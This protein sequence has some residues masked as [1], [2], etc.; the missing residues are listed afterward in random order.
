[1]AA[2]IKTKSTKNAEAK[3]AAETNGGKIRKVYT[4]KDADAIA[5]MRRD[6]KSWDAISAEHGSNGIV[7]RKQLAKFGYDAKGESNEIE[8]ITLKGSAL[9][10]RLLAERAEGVAWYTLAIA[11]GET[12]GNLKAL[13][14][15]AGGDTGRVHAKA[16]KP[17]KAAKATKAKSASKGARRKTNKA[18]AGSAA[19]PS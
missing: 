10:K 12:E 8:P 18:A 2:K 11:T 15:E 6:K 9:V 16:E 19:D 7:L 4:E 14:E 17:A 5:K 3:P 13:V 1:M